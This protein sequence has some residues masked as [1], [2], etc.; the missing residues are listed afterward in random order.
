V[1]KGMMSADWP[2]DVLTFWFKET[3]P[4]QWFKK[5]PAFDAAIRSRFLALHEILA[6]QPSEA[7]FADART[8]LASIILFDQMSRNMFRDT[9]RAFA[10]DRLARWIAE[11]AIAAGY[12]QDMTKDERQF[13][14]LPFEHAE[15]PKAQEQCVALMATLDDPEASKWALAHKVIIDRFGRFPHRNKILGR[16]ST[17]EEEEF[18]KQPDSSF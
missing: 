4:E 6:S 10:T 8:A 9:P 5:D 2:A 1:V 12:D 16:P 7:L 11:G 14:Y 17:P 15:D 3:K 13:M 18:L